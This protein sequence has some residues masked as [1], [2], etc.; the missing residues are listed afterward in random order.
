MIVLYNKKIFIDDFPILILLGPFWFLRTSLI[1]I[2][3][4]L[5]INLFFIGYFTHI[6]LL[7]SIYKKNIHRLIFVALWVI[8]AIFVIVDTI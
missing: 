3:I 8:C 4:F 5:T 1:P 6:C 2:V 7:A